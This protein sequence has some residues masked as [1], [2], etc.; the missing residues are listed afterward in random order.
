MDDKVT[1]WLTTNDH[2]HRDRVSGHFFAWQEII[3]E[4]LGELDARETVVS[5]PSGKYTAVSESCAT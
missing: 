5:M 2:S 3:H 1:S 4:F